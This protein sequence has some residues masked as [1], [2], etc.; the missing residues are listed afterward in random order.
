MHLLG[1]AGHPRRYSE[2]TGV[3][4]VAAMAPLQKIITYA[5]IVT[6]AGQII[7]LVN[8]FWSMF[9]GR[10][11]EAN[12][13]ECTTLEWTLAS[14]TPDEGFGPNRPSVSRGP[15]EYGG[16]GAADYQMQNSGSPIPGNHFQVTNFR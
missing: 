4:Y 7:F 8:F 16:D 5:A 12:P 11:A 14:P 6:L 10:R 13:W 1:I 15:Y 9:K 2:L 3:Q